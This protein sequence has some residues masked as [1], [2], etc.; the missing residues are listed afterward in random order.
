[1]TANISVEKLNELVNFIKEQTG[2]DAFS[3]SIDNEAKPSL[4]DSKIGGLPYW[5]KDRALIRPNQEELGEDECDFILLAQLD[6]TQFEGDPRLPKSGLLQFFITPDDL[7]GLEFDHPM[8]AQR[9]FR[10]IWHREIDETVT[11]QDVVAKGFRAANEDDMSP[12]TSEH[13]LHI[14]KTCSWMTP[15]DIRFDETC[16]KIC[17]E[18]LGIEI[19]EGKELW[20]FLGDEGWDTVFEGLSTGSGPQHLVLGYPFFTQWD[21]RNSDSVRYFNTLLFQ[22][23]SDFSG[24]DRVLWGDAG[25]GNFFINGNALKSG[26]FGRVLYNW[27]CY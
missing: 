25:I 8:D 6:L 19:P 21:P 24:K 14:T 12:V 26:D 13:L 17:K 23:D 7:C 18:K 2:V 10:V 22:L 1:M 11:E 3:L 27:D 9:R 4:T 16:A 5:P 15:A 20:D